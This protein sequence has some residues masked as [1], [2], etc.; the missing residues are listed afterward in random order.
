LSVVLRV[1]TAEDAAS[2]ADVLLSSRK[3]FLPYACLAHTDAEVRVWVRETLIPSGGV[4]V[5]CADKSVVGVIAT[6][7]DSGVSWVNRARSFWERHG[8]KAIAYSDGST[9]EERCPDVLYELA[10]CVNAAALDLRITPESA[11]PDTVAELVQ[12]GRALPPEER[13]KLVEQLLQSLNE[14][15]TRDLD[16]TWA[17]EIKKRLAEYDSGA[18]EAIDAE[19]VFARAARLAQ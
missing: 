1:A 11:M 12:R 7:C 3:A 6:S 8:F 19:E 5:A 17:V 10:F 18:V 13:E 15:A 9:N 16:A 2:V 14:S 4:T